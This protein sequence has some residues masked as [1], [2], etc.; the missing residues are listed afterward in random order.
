VAR[1]VGKQVVKLVDRLVLQ[2]VG[3]C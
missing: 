1:L 2:Q 3:A